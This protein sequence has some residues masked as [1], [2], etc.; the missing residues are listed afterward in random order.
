[1]NQKA[2]PLLIVGSIAFDD[3]ELPTST[4]KDV[5]GGSATYSR[6]AASVFSPVRIV[7]VVGSDFPSGDLEALVARAASTSRARARFAARRFAGPA[8]TTPTWSPRDARHPA[9]CLRRLQPQAARVATS[10]RRS[11]CSATS[12]PP[13]RSRCSTRSRAPQLVIADTMNFWIEG[14]PE[15]LGEMLKR[16]DLLVINDEEARQLAGEHNITQGGRGHPQARPEVAHHQARRVRR[17]PV[18][19]RVDVLRRPPIPLEDVVDPTGAGDT[20]AG[21]LHR[22]PR[23]D[24]RPLG[25][26]HAPRHH[27]RL[28]GGI[29]LRRS[30]GHRQSR[31]AECVGYQREARPLPQPDARVARRDVFRALGPPRIEIRGRRQRQLG[32][33]IKARRRGGLGTQNFWLAIGC[34][35]HRA[36]RR[37]TRAR[38]RGGLSIEVEPHLFGLPRISIRGGP[39][40]AS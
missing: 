22:L 2:S 9:Q 17:A 38:P 27:G 28:G 24:R 31:K 11:C 20:F 5:V 15:A 13:C 35:A 30:G 3:L 8:A 32:T 23:Q 10:T 19:R 34:R 29:V 25:P 39:R 36:T 33:S 26:R 4:A 14:K 18:R 40:R 6:Y 7:A 21:A 37:T 1:M 12:T 16:I